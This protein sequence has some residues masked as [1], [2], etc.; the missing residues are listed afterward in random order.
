M[1]V[2]GFILN[3]FS[4]LACR[5]NNTVFDH[6]HWSA[7]VLTD[8]P[9]SSKE[10]SEKEARNKL[11]AQIVDSLSML[12]AELGMKRIILSDLEY[13]NAGIMYV[14]GGMHV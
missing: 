10:N 11:N 1:R 12:T 6:N 13:L 7:S 3:P 5:L 8:T 9:N 4:I 14:Q 2:I